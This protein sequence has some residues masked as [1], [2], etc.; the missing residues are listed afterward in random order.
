MIVQQVYVQ[1]GVISEPQTDVSQESEFVPKSLVASGP[2][3][4][5]GL[6]LSRGGRSVR[7]LVMRWFLKVDSDLFTLLRGR[8]FLSIGRSSVVGIMKS[9]WRFRSAGI[10]YSSQARECLAVSLCS[11]A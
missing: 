9:M 7:W 5:S 1:A 8:A 10:L 11:N 3:N 6:T 2:F 4:E